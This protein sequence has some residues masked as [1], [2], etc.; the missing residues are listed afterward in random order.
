M[1]KV[2]EL[3]KELTMTTTIELT[4]YIL[5]VVGIINISSTIVKSAWYVYA[6]W[7]HAQSMNAKMENQS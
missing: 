6:G 7:K 4:I 2:Y 1:R 5:A 3:K